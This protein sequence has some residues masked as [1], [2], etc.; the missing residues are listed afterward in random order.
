MSVLNILI[1]LIVSWLLEYQWLL[2]R[3]LVNIEV[4]GWGDCN[5]LLSDPEVKKKM[6]VYMHTRTHTQRKK[7]NDKQRIKY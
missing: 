5:L 2:E 6:S 1:L 7:R 4:W 3:I